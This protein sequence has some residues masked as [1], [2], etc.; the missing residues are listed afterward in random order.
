MEETQ[1]RRSLAA[2][3]STNP[4]QKDSPSPP[5]HNGCFGDTWVPSSS[6]FRQHE[7]VF[8]SDHSKLL[9]P[10]SP[11]LWPTW[12]IAMTTQL[13]HCVKKRLISKMWL[14]FG[15]FSLRC[16]L[17]FPPRLNKPE[18]S[19]VGVTIVLWQKKMFGVFRGFE[20]FLVAYV[21]TRFYLKFRSVLL[22][23]KKGWTLPQAAFERNPSCICKYAGW[24]TQ[25]CQVAP[26]RHLFSTINPRN[27]GIFMGLTHFHRTSMLTKTHRGCASMRVLKSGLLWFRRRKS[28]R[29][30]D[31]R[32]EQ[33]RHAGII[34]RYSNQIIFWWVGLQ[35]QAKF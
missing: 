26:P 11:K 33:R 30:K 16:P 23:T 29:C 25:D 27:V 18:P 2:A 24:I 12:A 13:L 32:P 20:K 35:N 3:V 22:V 7:N 9:K 21:R 34:T 6:D 17:F 5:P 28:H 8:L 4:P 15:P 10:P 1:A 19:L 31:K 14:P